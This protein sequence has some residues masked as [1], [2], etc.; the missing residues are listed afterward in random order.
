MQQDVTIRIQVAGAADAQRQLTRLSDMLQSL[1]QLAT[2]AGAVAASLAVF[3]ATLSQISGLQLASNLQMLEL[4]FRALTGSEVAAADALSRFVAMARA[5]RFDTAEVA[6]FGAILM[7]TGVAIDDA[8]TQLSQLLDLM[9]AMGVARADLDRVLFNL[10]QIRSGA[11]T[12]A[13]V[14]QMLSAMPGIGTALG[15]ALGRAPLTRDEITA[16]LQE[17]GGEGFYALL[18]QAARRFEGASRELAI[19]DL[20]SN[21]RES[22]E[23]ALLPTGQ[24]LGGILGVLVRVGGRVVELFGALNRALGGVPGLILALAASAVAASSA[25][26]L[27]SRAGLIAGF[28]QLATLVRGIPA[29][30][31]RLPALLAGVLGALRAVPALL[32]RLPALLSG[33][34]GAVL[35][36]VGALL[37]VGVV[38]AV[39]TLITQLG[40]FALRAVGLNDAADALGRIGIAGGIGAT[41]G[42]ILGSIIPGLGTLAGG[43]IG[44]LAGLIIG[45]LRELLFPPQSRDQSSAAQQTARNTAEMA[46]TLRDLKVQIVGGGTRARYAATRYEIESYLARLAHAGI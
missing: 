38:G 40:A 13:D 7:S 44:G 17:R 19:G 20:L 16:L 45:G 18:L 37:R 35:T 33:S 15:T 36:R 24:L 4:Q 5:T 21:F 29:M 22:V 2:T 42:A 28:A 39:I 41:I 1:N 14:R 3:G 25:L 10:L 26:Q 31:G 43:L 34:L 46:Q 27:L 12:E 8:E 30:L 9:T 23:F 6:R 11:A 32:G